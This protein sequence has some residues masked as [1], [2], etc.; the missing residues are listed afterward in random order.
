MVNVARS[1][2]FIFVLPGIGGSGL[3]PLGSIVAIILEADEITTPP[4]FGTPSLIPL[5]IKLANIFR[6]DK[7]F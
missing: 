6:M 5:P 7:L 2:P 3:N 4:L 1:H